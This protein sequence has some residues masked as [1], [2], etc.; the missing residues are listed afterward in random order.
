MVQYHSGS[1]VEAIP[2]ESSW[3]SRARLAVRGTRYHGWPKR[4]GS[5][6]SRAFGGQVVGNP[7]SLS[8]RFTCGMVSKARRG[9]QRLRLSRFGA[10][11]PW[12]CRRPYRPRLCAKTGGA[13]APHV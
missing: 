12:V 6:V 2:P 11:A 8:A 13:G 10:C 5:M 3:G 1:R 7:E 9:G 4:R